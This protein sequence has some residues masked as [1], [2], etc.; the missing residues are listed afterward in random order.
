MPPLFSIYS[1]TFLHSH[2]IYIA[3]AISFRDIRG[4]FEGLGAEKGEEGEGRIFRRSRGTALPEDSRFPNRRNG[5]AGPTEAARGFCRCRVFRYGC[6]FSE[7]LFGLG[8][9]MLWG[10]PVKKDILAAPNGRH[11]HP[12][13]GRSV[14]WSSAIPGQ[15]TTDSVWL[16]QHCPLILFM[17]RKSV[18]QNQEKTHP[19]ILRNV[20]KDKRTSIQYYFAKYHWIL[21]PGTWD[22]QRAKRQGAGRKDGPTAELETEPCNQIQPD[23]P[24]CHLKQHFQ[25]PAFVFLR[26]TS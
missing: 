10:N 5:T 9:R 23:A 13:R 20:S 24:K 16:L 19:R 14:N 3:R 4:G 17:K 1:E 25:Q 8:Q 22:G 11:R 12:R 2:Y 15:V 21:F 26:K 18:W 6:C 7:H